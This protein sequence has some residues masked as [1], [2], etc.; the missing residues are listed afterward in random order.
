MV[1]PTASFLPDAF[2]RRPAPV[3]LAASSW[4]A[5]T[6]LVTVAGWVVCL[7]GLVAIARIVHVDIPPGLTM[8]L[9]LLEFKPRLIFAGETRTYYGVDPTVAA[10]H[11][12]RER[13]YAVNLAY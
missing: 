6:A 13:G 10:K 8:K 5:L 9:S 3:P 11:L 7:A 2:P 4:I 12:G 1:S